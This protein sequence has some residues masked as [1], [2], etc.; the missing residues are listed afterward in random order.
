[1]AGPDG[2]PIVKPPYYR[3][4]STDLNRGEHAWQMPLGD[5]PRNHPAIQHL[6]LGP[7]SYSGHYSEGKCGGILAGEL[8]LVCQFNDHSVD[9]QPP[10]FGSILHAFDQKNGELVAQIHLDAF[11][12]GTPMTCLHQGRQYL[13]V[14]TVSGAGGK[15][16]LVTLALGD[17]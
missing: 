16:E 6:K 9:G 1:M 5:G 7:L 14:S 13:V 8:F 17:K 4:T 2:L 12:L 15:G 3:V 10:K 11:A